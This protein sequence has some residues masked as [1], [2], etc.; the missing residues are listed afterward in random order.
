MGNRGA[1]FLNGPYAEGFV[2][3]LWKETVEDL[4]KVD[5]GLRRFA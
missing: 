3:R 5:V 4:A 2:E 1:A